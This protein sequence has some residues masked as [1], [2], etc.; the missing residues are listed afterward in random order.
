MKT[1]RNILI[2]FILNLSFSV[3]EF[4]GG[5]VTGSVA[6]ASDAVHDM[7]DAASIGV[8]YFAEKKSKRPSDENYTF[9]YGRYSAIGG[10]ITTAI[11]L[12]GSAVMIYNS[13]NRIVSPEELDYNGM[14]FFAVVGVGVNFCAALF[15][16]HGDSLNQK[17]V[18]LHMLE[19]VL[20]WVVVL[21]G[22]IVMRFTD[23]AVID[24]VMSIGVSVFI[25]VNACKNLKE[26]FELFLEKVPRNITVKEV[27][28]CVEAIDGVIEV[29]RIHL[30]SID[31]K[32]NCAT[33]HVVSR[34]DL[35]KIKAE[36]REELQKYGVNLITVET[37]S[38]S[39][40]EKQKGT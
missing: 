13:A 18:N 21:V 36:M 25:L 38:C 1:E 2:A 6:V 10:L 14:I 26:T 15:T 19:D 20:G 27:K 3:F 39:E 31:G 29:H 35:S 32:N 24:P 11:L 9:G 16:R 4:I 5:V 17:A 12:L 30:W 28:E 23:F 8:S 40:Y 37:E 34:G 33:M 7:G 22:A